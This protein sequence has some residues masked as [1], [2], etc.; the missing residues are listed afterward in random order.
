M[1]LIGVP[2]FLSQI[3]GG[4]WIIAVALAILT[5][6]P[7]LAGF[8]YL[9]SILTTR[10]NEKV[11]LPGRPIE[12]Y[13]TFSKKSDSVRYHG[14]KI[15]IDTFQEMY[16]DGDVEFNGD[17]LEVLEYRHD[18]ANFRFTLRLFKYFLLGFVPEM[19]RHSRSQG[20]ELSSHS[21]FAADS[22]NTA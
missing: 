16:F 13:L 12:Y 9:S 11:K 17:C 6:F 8:W 1:L 22:A 3:I 20:N 15:P 7:L 4:G 10:K 14:R 2:I 18:W 5:S 19:I 21:V